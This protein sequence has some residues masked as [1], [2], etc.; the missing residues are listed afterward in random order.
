MLMGKSILITVL[1]LFH[2][3]PYSRINLSELR[4][5]ATIRKNVGIKIYN[6]VERFRMIDPNV[7]KKI[8]ELTKLLQ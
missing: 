5:I 8:K 4:S 1:D 6:F 7:T 3:N 2:L